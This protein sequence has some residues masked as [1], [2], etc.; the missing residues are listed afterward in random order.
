MEPSC[1]NRTKRNK[2]MCDFICW[3]KRKRSVHRV[4]IRITL[5]VGFEDI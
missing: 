1:V 2:I 5:N 4:Q 3:R